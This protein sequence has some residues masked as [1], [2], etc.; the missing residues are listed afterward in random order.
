MRAVF[1]TNILIDYLNGH[2]QAMTTLDQYRDRLIS[3]ISWME[4]LVG[5]EDADEEAGARDFLALFTIV[6]VGPEVSELAIGLRRE[7]HLRLPDAIVLASAHLHQCLLVTRNT[8]D[9]H[10]DW[11]EV[12]VPYEL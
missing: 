6:E 5:A 10:R 8:R 4:V 9:F 2:D 1:D 11:V 12:R 3:R 7:R